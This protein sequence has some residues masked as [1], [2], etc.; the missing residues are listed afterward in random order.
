MF[1]IIP[2]PITLEDDAAI[3]STVTTLVATDSDGTA[4]G[5]KVSLVISIRTTTKHV[6]SGEV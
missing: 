3:G 2:H 5:N 1:T 4:P 6:I